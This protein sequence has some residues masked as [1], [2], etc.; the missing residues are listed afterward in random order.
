MDLAN[1]FTMDYA[2][3]DVDTATFG[4]PAY[5]PVH[6]LFTNYGSFGQS[7]VYPGNGLILNMGAYTGS[8]TWNGTDQ[9]AISINQETEGDNFFVNDIS[10]HMSAH[11][12]NFFN[13]NGAAIVADLDGKTTF[14]NASTAHSGNGMLT[15]TDAYGTCDIY[16]A[17]TGGI[18]SLCSSDRRLKYDIRN[19]GG[20]LGWLDSFRIRSYRLKADG[21]RVEAGV[22]AQEVMKKHPKM[23]RGNPDNPKCSVTDTADC[24]EVSAPGLWRMMKAMQEMQTEIVSLKQKVE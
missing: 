23:V 13:S 6:D 10:A 24:M 5:C 8:G 16:T 3:Y 9:P 17:S 15:I 19:A 20:Q 7:A 11:F 14:G 18:G 21:E 22:I 1:L 12:L 2:C 4:N